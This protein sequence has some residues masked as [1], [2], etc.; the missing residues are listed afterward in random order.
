MAATGGVGAGGSA[1]SKP[2]GGPGFEVVTAARDAI[3]RYRMAA[4][5][6]KVLVALSGGPDSTCLFDVLRRLQEGLDLELEVAHVD[7]GS[8][9]ESETVAARVAADAAAAGANV[10]VIR[11][12]ALEGPNFHARARDFRYAFFADVA[13]SIGAAAV[14]TGHTLDDRVETTLA[15]LVHGA[16]TGGLAGLPP[17][18]A[19]RIRPLI[20]VRRAET[21]AYCAGAGLAFYDDPGNE[22]DRYE[23]VFIRQCLVAAIE[24]RWG[25]GGVR[26]V[27]TSA[28]R[29]LDDARALDLIA[30][31][32]WP[33]LA[34][35]GDEV[36]LDVAALNELPRGLRR[37]IL[38]RAVGRVRDRAGGI[39]AVL[40]ALD[41]G[42]LRQ[43]LKWSVAEARE[44]VLE[45]ETLVV[46]RIGS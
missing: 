4:G 2:L 12:P 33:R 15:R 45:G 35:E 20:D 28:A 44:I 9:P 36:R 10:H 30:D 18:E 21:R 11:A 29:L 38:E 27:A 17:N 7:H 8:G 14:A 25:D 23:R 31:R 19:G 42:D 3:E 46:R 13:R 34:Q 41:G 24:Q 1:T 22:D 32:A 26:A 37:R 5:G 16:G 40:D 39:D 6:A 43:G